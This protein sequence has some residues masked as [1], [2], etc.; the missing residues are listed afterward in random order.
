MGDIQVI[1]NTIV[2]L[3]AIVAIVAIVATVVIAIDEE[4][5]KD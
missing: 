3:V 2:K 4:V 1:C 5:G